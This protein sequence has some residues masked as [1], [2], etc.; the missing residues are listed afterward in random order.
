MKRQ[1]AAAVLS[2]AV[3]VMGGVSCCIARGS[4]VRTP[5]GDRLIETLGAGDEVLAVD[6]HSLEVLEARLVATRSSTRETIVL[7][8]E[9]FSLRCTTDHPLWDPDARSWADAGDW[10]LRRR[11]ALLLVGDGRSVGRVEV[12]EVDLAGGVIEVFDLSVDHPV[13][14]FVAEGI[15]VHNKP[16]VL[17]PDDAC[18]GTSLPCACG[19]ELG[20]SCTDLA[21]RVIGAC[22]CRSSC[23]TSDGAPIFAGQCA[24]PAWEPSAPDRDLGRAPC[25]G[26]C[27]CE[28]VVP[29]CRTPAGDV[30]AVAEAD[31]GRFPALSPTRCS[32]VAGGLGTFTCADPAP[33]QQR[34][35]AARCDCTPDC[36]LPDGGPVIERLA[37]PCRCGSSSTSPRGTLRCGSLA[38]GGLAGACT[39]PDAGP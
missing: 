5:R 27:V 28:P 37:E 32:C 25:G 36:A 33:N 34:H 19:G 31:G 22:D 17:P 13:H 23:Q 8:G 16:P 7:T 11:T 12:R 9:G 6:P 2:A 14:T 35:V 20:Q 29:E 38:D 26:A 24:C 18:L 10:A 39:C 30:L 4:R 3:G 15:V 21:G 1:L